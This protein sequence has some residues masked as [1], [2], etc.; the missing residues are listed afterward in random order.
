MDQLEA[1]LGEYRQAS[2]YDPSN[3]LVSVKV[4]DLDKTIRDRVEAA[5]PKPQIQQL[6]ERA[7]AAST[8]PPLLNFTT[9]LRR[10]TFNNTSV[11]DILNVIADFNRHQ[12]GLRPGST[13]T[14]R[15]R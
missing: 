15:S 4:A 5:R 9:P 10:I 3:R 11:R 2:E 13:W 6:R 1:A 14:G 7:R 12:R 8:P